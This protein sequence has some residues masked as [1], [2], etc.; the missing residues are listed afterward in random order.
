M[1]APPRQFI[2]LQAFNALKETFLGYCTKFNSVILLVAYRVTIRW[3]TLKKK[4]VKNNPHG[5]RKIL[6][7]GKATQ[8]EGIVV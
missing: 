6:C 7:S 1:A 3:F 5:I 2:A 4:N 8:K